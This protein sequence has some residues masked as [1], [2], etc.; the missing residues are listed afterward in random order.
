[1]DKQA[2]IA[3]VKSLS[4]DSG[5]KKAVLNYVETRPYGEN[6]PEEVA[7]LLEMAADK[8]DLD[9][10]MLSKVGDELVKF[11]G[12]LEEEIDTYKEEVDKAEESFDDQVMAELDKEIAQ[13]EKSGEVVQAPPTEQVTPP[14]V[15]PTEQSFMATPIPPVENLPYQNPAQAEQPDQPVQS[16]DL[17]MT[18]PVQ[19]MQGQQPPVLQTPPPTL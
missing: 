13:L 5:V 10:N 7:K 14:A 8:A 3:H 12:K 6:T 9:A 15:S 2:L 19:E 16:V 4:I 18:P 17:G 1:M 11:K